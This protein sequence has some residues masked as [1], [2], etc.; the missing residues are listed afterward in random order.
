MTPAERVESE[1]SGILHDKCE[2]LTW[3]ECDA[4]ARLIVDSEDFKEMA[5]KA[6]CYEDLSR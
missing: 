3:A 6:W 1:I 5:H 2:T 4:L